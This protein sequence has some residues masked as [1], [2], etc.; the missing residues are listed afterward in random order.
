MGVRCGKSKLLRI[1]PNELFVDLPRMEMNRGLS[2]LRIQKLRTTA[3]RGSQLGKLGG[4]GY[5]LE[6]SSG[7]VPG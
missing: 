2:W 7:R 6:T 1:L 4:R 5:R 3:T